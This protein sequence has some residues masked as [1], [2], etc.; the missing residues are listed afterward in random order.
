[1]ALPNH[2]E[3]DPISHNCAC[4][5]CTKKRHHLFDRQKDKDKPALSLKSKVYEVKRLCSSD[6]TGPMLDEIV[7]EIDR[8]EAEN[9]NLKEDLLH[10]IEG[11][12]WYSVTKY[13]NCDKM[14]KEI[15][16]KDAR[17]TELER[18][19]EASKEMI[20]MAIRQFDKAEE[21]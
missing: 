7:V 16:A 11:T 5:Q 9:K 8:F 17:I 4:P 21:R 13:A 15:V 3:V 6:I 10:I 19:L 1:M 18:L 20:G 2:T 12:A 14:R